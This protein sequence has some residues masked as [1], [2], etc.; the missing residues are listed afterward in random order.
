LLPNK[1]L[2]QSNQFKSLDNEEQIPSLVEI[3]LQSPYESYLGGQ[4]K[5]LLS[6]WRLMEELLGSSRHPFAPDI[7]VHS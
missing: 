6:V 7:K 2:Y 3:T 5:N 1:L 4:I